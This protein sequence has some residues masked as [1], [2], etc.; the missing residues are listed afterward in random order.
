MFIL[1]GIAAVL[2]VV[3]SSYSFH[4]YYNGGLGTLGGVAGALIGLFF[5]FI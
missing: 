5:L 3:F 1:I 4:A 2:G